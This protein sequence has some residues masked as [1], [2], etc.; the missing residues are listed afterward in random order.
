MGEHTEGG[1]WMSYAEL[2]AA[3]RVRRSTVVRLAR[4]RRWPKQP[5]NDGTIRVLVPPGWDEPAERPP[6]ERPEE[7]PSEPPEAQAFLLALE[8]IN[9]AHAAEVA[10][11]HAQLADAQGRAQRTEAEAEELRQRD[12]ARRA[13]RDA[14]GLLARLLDAWRGA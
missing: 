2:A 5:A 8:E 6:M 9:R 11:M 10:A 3:R 7:P 12:A 14:M 1:R 13:Q 4:A